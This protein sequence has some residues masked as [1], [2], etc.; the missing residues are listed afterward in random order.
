M[1][2]LVL[3]LRNSQTFVDN[4]FSYKSEVHVITGLYLI[5]AT[6]VIYRYTII[7]VIYTVP[8]LDHGGQFLPGRHIQKCNEILTSQKTTVVIMSLELHMHQASV[9]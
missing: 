3:F 9:Q 8:H 4:H 6:D 2:Y 1:P 5:V 7:Y